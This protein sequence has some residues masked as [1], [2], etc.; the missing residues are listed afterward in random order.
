VAVIA[1]DVGDV[2]GHQH[3]EDRAA[4]RKGCLG[5]RLVGIE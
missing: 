2:D 4:A 3:R 5:C 1:R